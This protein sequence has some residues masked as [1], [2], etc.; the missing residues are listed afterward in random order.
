MASY[1]TLLNDYSLDSFRETIVKPYNIYITKHSVSFRVRRFYEIVNIIIPFF[2]K[3]PILGVKSLDF[4]DFQKVAE[5]VKNKEHLTSTGFKTIQRINSSMNLR[6]PW[7]SA[8][9]KAK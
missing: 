4:A 7:G 9:K 2:D 1:F 5:L 3:Y 6:R 8:D